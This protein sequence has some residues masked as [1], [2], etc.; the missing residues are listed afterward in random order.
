MKVG[1]WYRWRLDNKCAQGMNHAYQI[2]G[3]GRDFVVFRCGTHNTAYY[4]TKVDFDGAY[5]LIAEAQ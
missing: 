1:D 4:N 2:V 5:E 3:V